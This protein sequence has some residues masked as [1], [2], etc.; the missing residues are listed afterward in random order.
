MHK[1]VLF[2][3]NLPNHHFRE[4][5]YLDHVNRNSPPTFIIN[6]FEYIHS[7][8]TYDIDIFTKVEKTRIWSSLGSCALTIY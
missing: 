1:N 6:I 5:Y 7:S 2:L 3:S 4:S 8:I